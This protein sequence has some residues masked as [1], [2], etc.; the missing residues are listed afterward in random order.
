MRGSSTG[1]V[2]SVG[3]SVRSCTNCHQ[4]WKLDR[5]R[6]EQFLHVL[7][8]A[9]GHVLEFRDPSWYADD[10]SALLERYNV[11]RCLQDMKGSAT[12][13]SASDRSFTSASTEPA[14]RTAEGI[15]PGA[16]SAWGEWLRTQLST[17]VDVYAYFNNDVGGHAPV[18]APTLRRIV[19][20]TE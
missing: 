15:Q 4:G 8:P 1:S 13:R 11:A 6:L 14:V 3:T 16:S 2:R 20:D 10:V 7:P 12:D 18:D 5:Q 9:V 17:G 19:E